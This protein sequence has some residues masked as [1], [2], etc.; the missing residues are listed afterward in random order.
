MLQALVRLIRKGIFASAKAEM[1]EQ[2][3]L[4]EK[5]HASKVYKIV[6]RSGSSAG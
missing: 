2:R 1:F 5:R 6:A 3:S 4:T